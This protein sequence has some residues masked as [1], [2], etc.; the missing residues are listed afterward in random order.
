V[1]LI[2]EYCHEE[3]TCTVVIFFRVAA[4]AVEAGVGAAAA[5]A[6]GGAGA[7][8]TTTGAKDRS[9]ELHVT[10]GLSSIDVALIYLLFISKAEIISSFGQYHAVDTEF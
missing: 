1:Y 8:V 9:L 10:K 5:A 2:S 4:L 7:A 6:V 3:V